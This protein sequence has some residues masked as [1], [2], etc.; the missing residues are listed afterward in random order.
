M[1]VYLIFLF[2]LAAPVLVR[3]VS[4]ETSPAPSASAETP[5]VSEESPAR[6]PDA[7]RSPPSAAKNQTPV[8]AELPNSTPVKDQP[9]S[10]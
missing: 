5:L 3:L 1:K 9:R 2:L 4:T 6:A 10:L 8:S 7:T